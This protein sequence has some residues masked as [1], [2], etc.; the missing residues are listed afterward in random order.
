MCTASSILPVR[1]VL[2]P[3]FPGFA[4]PDRMPKTPSAT[5]SG[6]ATP[7]STTSKSSKGSYSSIDLQKK[8]EASRNHEE[9]WSS[10]MQPSLGARAQVV[11]P[12]S[13]LLS[14]PV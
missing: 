9:H 5:P 10:W 7:G 1:T 3:I 2:A 14:S 12:G 8:F 4:F 13:L 11:G 6:S